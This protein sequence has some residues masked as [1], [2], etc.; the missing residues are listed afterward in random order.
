MTTKTCTIVYG[1]QGCGKTTNAH[2]IAKAY[3]CDKIV[4]TGKT[5]Q[6]HVKP[7]QLAPGTL[8]LC[9]ENPDLQRARFDFPIRVVTYKVAMEMVKIDEEGR[10]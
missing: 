10:A 9:T 2:V 6:T 8:I 5:G 4:D 3:G 1:P 7:E